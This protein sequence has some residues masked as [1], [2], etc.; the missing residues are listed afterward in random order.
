VCC[1]RDR[2]C[3]SSHFRSVLGTDP[4][5]S[6]R[7]ALVSVLVY[8]VMAVVGIG[9]K[10]STLRLVALGAAHRRGLRI[11]LFSRMQEFL[12]QGLPVKTP[13]SARCA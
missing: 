6:G 5:R 1:D 2:S 3:V 7:F 11:Y 9:L 12:R 13:T 4:R 8:A 10:V